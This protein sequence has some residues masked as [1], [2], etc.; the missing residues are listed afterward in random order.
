MNRNLSG[1]VLHPRRSGRSAEKAVSNPWPRRRNGE[2]WHTGAEERAGVGTRTGRRSSGHRSGPGR[3]DPDRCWVPQGESAVVGNL[4]IGGMVYVGKGLRAE[5]GGQVERSLIDP[6][7]PVARRVPGD[8]RLT[9]YRPSYSA[10]SPNDRLGYLRWLASDRS[11]P[12]VAPPFLRLY[13]FGLERRLVLDGPGDGERLALLAEVRRLGDTYGDGYGIGED[14]ESLLAFA[15]AMAP[16]DLEPDPLG[17]LEQRGHEQFLA[18]VGLGYRLAA[19]LPITGTWLLC[20]WLAASR[21]AL[22]A[23][24]R[25]IFEEFALL[26]EVRCDRRYP[27]GVPVRESTPVRNFYYS[28]ASGCFRSQLVEEENAYPDAIA[29]DQPVRLA[30]RIAAECWKALRSFSAHVARRPLEA[31]QSIAAHL[32]LPP[33]MV[34]RRHCLD[35]D[36]LHGM[37]QRCLASGEPVPRF[38]DLMERIGVRGPARVGRK[39]LAMVADA[40]AIGGYGLAPAPRYSPRLPLP[41]DRAVL[42]RLPAPAA[43]AADLS[44]RYGRALMMLQL[45]VFVARTEGAVAAGARAE[46][47]AFIERLPNLLSVDRLQLAADLHWLARARMTLASIKQPCA[48]LRADEL[49]EVCRVAVKSACADGP[50]HPD[51]VKAVQKLYR[52]MGRP[53]D[54]VFSILHRGSADAPAEIHPGPVAGRNPAAFA[55]R[56]RTERPSEP[57]MQPLALDTSRIS[58]IVEDT[59]RVSGVLSEVFTEEEP[60]G[61]PGEPASPST[62]SGLDAA[63]RALVLALVARPAW[64]HGEFSG[65]VRQSGLMAGGALE[66]VNEWSFEHFGDALLEEEDRLIVNPEVVGELR[67]SLS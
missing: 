33:D 16:E 34:L 31:R 18:E 5:T 19:G 23:S 15:A 22:S 30:E 52:A 8:G 66:A 63:H 57:R 36:A 64:S 12:D 43:R 2:P 6:D 21:P 49:D 25:R 1:R 39:G 40:L 17:V 61:A 42:F 26:F 51:A 3:S 56:R 38:R 65:L 46:V 62:F 50:V 14:V 41:G 37:A 54:A 44:A 20:W 24:R 35:L 10:L 11:D 28:A 4:D 32:L 29:S 55:S 7:L 59:R 47:D 45:V 13:F 53:V 9:D 67:G 60:E 27:Q 58:S 48:C